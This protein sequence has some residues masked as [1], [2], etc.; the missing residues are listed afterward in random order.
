MLHFVY[1][2]HVTGVLVNYSRKEGSFVL[3]LPEFPPFS[4][5]LTNDPLEKDRF[6]RATINAM[7]GEDR[8]LSES[9]LE[10]KNVGLWTLPCMFI[11]KYYA[12]HVFFCGD[13]AH[14]F[15]PAGGF[16]MNTGLQEVHGLAHKLKTLLG[17][18]E[19]TEV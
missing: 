14:L 6:A 8:Q 15:P 12:D 9:E 17:Q 4:W 7:L 18:R 16:G 13:S 11:E 19:L 10:I 5:L 2:K 3:Q 1:N